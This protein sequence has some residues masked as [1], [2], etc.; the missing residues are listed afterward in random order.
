[1]ADPTDMALTLA[2]AQILQLGKHERTD[3]KLLEIAQ[4]AAAM[5]APALGVVSVDEVARQLQA[6]FDVWV[7]QAVVVSDPGDHEPWLEARK[8]QISVQLLE[9][10]PDLPAEELQAGGDGGAG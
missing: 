3:A 5:L 9:P 7:P 2:R 6:E 10:V 8:H 4:S 1:M